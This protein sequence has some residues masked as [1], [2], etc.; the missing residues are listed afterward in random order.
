MF[1]YILL[2]P[3]GISFSVRRLKRSEPIA[4]D[5]QVPP[6]LERFALEGIKVADILDRSRSHPEQALSVRTFTENWFLPEQHDYVVVDHGKL[7]GIVSLS[8]L[9]YVPRSEWEHTPLSRVLR[10]ST[11]HANSSEY[12]E[13]VL[14]RMTENSLTVLPVLETDTGEFIGS[15]SSYEVLDMIVLNLSWSRNLT[16]FTS[17]PP[18]TAFAQFPHPTEGAA[19]VPGSRTNDRT[20]QSRVSPFP[21]LVA[22]PAELD[23]NHRGLQSPGATSSHKP[24]LLGTVESSGECD[25]LPGE[26]P[27]AKGSGRVLVGLT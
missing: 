4:R 2:T 7:A 8:M 6:S 15:I 18:S 19:P 22:Y 25:A 17:E 14:Q 1:V 9:R 16:P 12:V 13:D 11:P 10:R 3:M 20:V 21:S 26:S 5:E 23:S 27:S 24:L